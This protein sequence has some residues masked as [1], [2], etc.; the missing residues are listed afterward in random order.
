M[1]SGPCFEGQCLRSKLV[2]GPWTPTP[3]LGTYVDVLVHFEKKTQKWQA[4]L[5][6][7]HHYEK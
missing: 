6:W 4:D 2:S 7:Q 5:V 1:V 3:A